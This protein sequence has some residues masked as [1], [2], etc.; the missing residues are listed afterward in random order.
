MKRFCAAAILFFM[1]V[2]VTAQE[3]VK[4]K[5]QRKGEFYFSWG[6]NKEWYTKS[7]LFVNQPSLGYNYQLK[8]ITGHDHIG[9][10]EGI[11]SI[12]ISI[13]QYN[14][15]IGFLINRKKDLFFEIN[16]DHTKYIIADQGAH[17]VGTLNNRT[18][19]STIAFTETNGFL[20]YLNNGANFLLF[21]L[22]KRYH[23][24]ESN[25]KQF[26]L[27]G[28]LKVGIGPVIPHVQNTLFGKENNQGFQL[29]GWNI[30]TEAALRATFFKSVYL[31]FANKIDY[32]RYSGLKI[33]Q[34]KAHQ[35]FGTYEV[36]LSLGF[37]FPTG[38]KIN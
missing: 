5:K 37:T 33:Y 32:A 6:Y 36:I 7:S 27:D 10:D 25:S 22:A 16:F 13:P 23:F 14:Y 28:F 12:P 21:N 1:I 29:G 34:G 9:W 38:K 20:Y 19:D 2:N 3:T 4:N 18:V 15:R 26:K 24:Y 31:E 8:N 35:A 17:I 11:F 30:G